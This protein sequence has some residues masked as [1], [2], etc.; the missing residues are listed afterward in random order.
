MALNATMCIYIYI[1]Y[2]YIDAQSSVLA[3]P[4]RSQE[5]INRVFTGQAVPFRYSNLVRVTVHAGVKADLI[6][7]KS[8]NKPRTQ[9][10]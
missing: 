2:I 6:S 5:Q 3:T 10:R 8:A 1:L 7:L 4:P 9:R